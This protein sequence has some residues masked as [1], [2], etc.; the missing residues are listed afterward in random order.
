MFAPVTE[1]SKL[2]PLSEDAHSSREVDEDA[3]NDRDPM[4]W[5]DM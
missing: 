4:S 5:L 3:Y 2:V 1:F